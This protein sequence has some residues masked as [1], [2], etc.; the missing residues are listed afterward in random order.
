MSEKKDKVLSPA[1]LRQSMR[2]DEPSSPGSIPFKS[3]V[4]NLLTGGIQCSFITEISGNPSMFKS[5]LA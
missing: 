2:A 3:D 5:T 4:L 1:E